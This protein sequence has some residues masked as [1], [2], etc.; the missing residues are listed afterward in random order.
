MKILQINTTVNTGSTGRIAEE[1]GFQLKNAGWESYIA[2]QIIR[3]SNS[4]IIKIGNK[5][6]RYLHGIQTRIF[7]NHGFASK[8]STEILIKKIKNIDPDIIHL[9]NLHGYYIHVGKLFDYL[10]ISEKPVVWNIHDCWSFTGHCSYFD[11]V[12]CYRWKT[13]CYK[14]PNKHGYP[15]SWILDNSTRNF[16]LKKSVFS[17]IKRITIVPTSHWLYNNLSESFLN[18]YPTTVIHT[19]IDLNVFKPSETDVPKLWDGNMKWDKYILGVSNIWNKRKGLDDFIK[20]RNLLPNNVGIILI[21]LKKNQIKDLPEGIWGIERTENIQKLALFY[22]Q[23]EVFVNPT[24][25]DNFPNV[26]VEALACGTPV[27]TYQT[28]GSPEAIDEKT[29]IVVPKGDINSLAKAVETVLSRGKEFYKDACRQRAETCFNP[30]I[31]INKYIEI[32][33]KLLGR[34]NDNY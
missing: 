11:G 15:S 16:Q 1:I 30:N 33:E 24:Y 26:N 28:G 21:G 7:D 31:Q 34:N 23:A 9:H 27:I 13:V 4:N 14:C 22:S 3:P 17:G 20:L 6:D 10:K 18:I 25:M 29:G 12:N 8:K 19:S 2:G 32:Y 5:L